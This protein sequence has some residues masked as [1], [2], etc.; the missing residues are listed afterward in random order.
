MHTFSKAALA[1]ALLA[2]L[3][4]GALAPARAQTSQPPAYTLTILGTL[5]GGSNS[6]G[7]GVNASGQVTGYAD[8]GMTDANGNSLFHAFLTGPN[9]GGRT[10]LGA[11]GD[12]T[13][14]SFGSGVN[15]N[16]DVVGY[17]SDN[18][19]TLY[20]FF[21]PRGA[22]LTQYGGY[23]VPAAS[24]DG[25]GINASGQVTG[26]ATATASG[27]V[28]AYLSRPNGTPPFHTLGFLPGGDFSEGFGV[29]AGGQ[30]TG[31]ARAAGGSYH[32]F[33]SDPNGG[34]LHD[35][36]TLPGGSSSIGTGVNARGQVAGYAYL[37]SGGTH[38]FLSGPNGGALRDLGLLPGGAYSQADSV[39]DSGQVVGTSASGAFLYSGGV[40]TDL[41]TLIPPASGH[42]AT[43]V[44]AEA[45]SISNNGF[46]T[47]HGAYF[48]G[49]FTYAFLLTPVPVNVGPKI[50]LTAVASAAVTGTLV[51]QVNVTSTNTGGAAADMLQIKSVT[52]NGGM[53]IPPPV[54]NSPVPTTPNNL[55]NSPGMNTQQNGFAFAPPLGTK[56][57]ILK[58]SINYT[59]PNTGVTSSFI[60]TI[61]LPLP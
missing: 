36:G 24:R 23:Y 51:R 9:G 34:A 44:L 4:A 29:N 35:L 57:A 55:S 7:T 11:T 26:N 22:S 31:E 43:F 13:G 2:S 60:A 42:Q 54:S 12:G 48:D 38:A 15:D 56:P 61:R 25:A 37:A 8:L 14:S 21:D 27:H 17:G 6:F 50:T 53:P 1:A 40:L 45:T 20:L 46:I 30:V 33:L 18:S 32:A 49:A 5:P 58:V 52:L 10:D 16:G 19:G 47:G 59:D 41:N 3:G 28:E 39:N